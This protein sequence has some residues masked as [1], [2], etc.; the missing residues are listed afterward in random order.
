[1]KFIK[2]KEIDL[3]KSDLLNTNSYSKGII[4]LIESADSNASFTIGLF[5]EWGSGKSSI[6]YTVQEYFLK[7]NTKTRF[8][9]YDAW[10]Y[11]NDSFRRMF[12]LEIQRALRFRPKKKFNNF[13]ASTSSDL[14]IERKP[15]MHFVLLGFLMLILLS[16]AIMFGVKMDKIP[17]G[18]LPVAFF[19]SLAALI[20][21]WLGR[22]FVDYKYTIQ[23]PV[24]VAG[25]KFESCFDDMIKKALK[26]NGK[27]NS[28]WVEDGGHTRN[29]EKI[30][31]VID[32]IDRCSDEIALELMNSVKNFLG[33]KPNLYFLLPVD[34]KSLL[35]HIER[36]GISD[37]NSTEFLRKFFDII[38][39]IKHFQVYD[40]F[41][42]TESLNKD[43]GLKYSPDTIDV[44]SQEFVSNPRQIIQLINNLAFE[45]E[46]FRIR[47]KDDFVLKYEAL[48]CK[49]LILR[50]QWPDYYRQV[51]MQPSLL[52]KPLSETFSKNENLFAFINVTG[53]IHADV[54]L[55]VLETIFAIRDRDSLVN[56]EVQKAVR[57]KEIKKL[58]ELS[59]QA[60]SPEHLFNYLVELLMKSIRDQS[61]KISSTQYL[62]LL[63]HLNSWHPLDLAQFRK[64]YEVVSVPFAQFGPLT[65]PELLIQFIG[66]SKKD[67][68]LLNNMLI[69]YFEG[70]I[71]SHSP[72]TDQ[73]KMAKRLL[74]HYLNA[75][76]DQDSINTLQPIFEFCYT[77]EQSVRNFD[78]KPEAWRS[79]VRSNLLADITGKVGSL[80]ETEADVT[81]NELH[82]LGTKLQFTNEE[83]EFIF[84]KF[85][86]YLPVFGAVE[87]SLVY[88]AFTL[89]TNILRTQKPYFEAEAT[90]EETM[91][92]L[93]KIFGTKNS[94]GNIIQSLYKVMDDQGQLLY[95]SFS[96]E[97]YRISNDK[98]G[99]AN[100]ID[101]VIKIGSA[102]QELFRDLLEL[103]KD[104]KFTLSPIS[105][106]IWS[107]EIRSEEHFKVLGLLAEWDLKD[108]NFVPINKREKLIAIINNASD[109]SGLEIEF[110]HRVAKSS[111][112][113]WKFLQDLVCQ[114]P[115][116]AIL[117]KA[118]FIRVLGLP[119]ITKH[120]PSGAYKANQEV[121]QILLR[122]G[123]DEMVDY[124]INAMEPMFINANQ[125]EIVLDLLEWA[126]KF[127]TE[128]V[129]KIRLLAFVHLNEH[130]QTE[131][132]IILANKKE[133]YSKIP[134]SELNIIRAVYKT[135]ENGK[136][137]MLTRILR[138]MIKDKKLEFNANDDIGGDPHFGNTK[139][140]T[141][142]Y[143]IN[144]NENTLTIPQNQNVLIPLDV[145]D[146]RTW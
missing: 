68:R 58:E 43:Y 90:W 9:V 111:A 44:I 4:Q 26:G 71:R 23:E 66:D 10:K 138:K 94:E 118:Y 134:S 122:H 69:K 84:M 139:T 131:L 67:T 57:T 146:G 116:E 80:S 115:V 124:V 129:S 14:N 50:E 87:I 16:G 119:V 24:I 56:E 128:Q 30:I 126:V 73:F 11:S 54:S 100:V 77:V 135:D 83:I 110:L 98:F 52:T 127:N 19:V 112:P 64:V 142:Q 31:I 89:L 42:F 140:L 109:D 120:V 78:L 132:D 65:D 141:L 1:M 133:E 143:H 96:V 104:P 40:L 28:E 125:H 114:L 63:C 27:I 3:S 97:I 92:F 93:N 25:E 8:I 55:Q 35:S 79:I 108:G 12:L 45:L 105:D 17:D 48:I 61:Y 38:I 106:L 37:K 60:I 76:T 18:A 22:A 2:D 5:G 46:F 41:D 36:K 99:H 29:L 85:N 113:A 32:N 20:L 137:V 123:N 21:N 95:K 86:N 51:A 82:F 145:S 47:Y 74:Q 130:L 53:S 88:Q 49:A 102:Q 144:G 59:K 72:Q 91:K 62:E 136:E 117:S 15:D 107:T 101:E 39:R 103:T 81:L 75:G 33:N 13:Y 34:E 7:K 6:I 121:F 70:H